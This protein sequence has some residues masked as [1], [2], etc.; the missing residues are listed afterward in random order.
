MVTH[1]KDHLDILPRPLLVSGSPFLPSLSTDALPTRNAL[2]H[3]PWGR[4]NNVGI[5]IVIVVVIFLT[6]PILYSKLEST[7]EVQRFSENATEV[8]KLLETENFKQNQKK[9]LRASRE[10]VRKNFLRA[11]REKVR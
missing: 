11:S 8:H 1:P 7:L 9:F 4:P 5:V 3:T 6:F 2:S 10:K